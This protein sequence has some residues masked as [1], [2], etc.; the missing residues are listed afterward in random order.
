MTKFEKNAN[1]FV[2]GEYVQYRPNGALTAYADRKF[3]ARFKHV[4]SNKA[5]FVKFL[6]KHFTV[7]E[8]FELMEK[9]SPAQALETKGYVDAHIL[10]WLKEGKLQEWK[11]Q[12]YDHWK[13]FN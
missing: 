7:E 3:V 2:E 13:K 11:G 10:K 4:K 8:Y 12:G 6:C 5:G 1:L 9:T